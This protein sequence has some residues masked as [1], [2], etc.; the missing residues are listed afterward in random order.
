MKTDNL[1][2]VFNPENFIVQLAGLNI[3]LIDAATSPL[4]MQAIGKIREREFR[5]EG[6]GTGKEIDVDRFDFEAPCYRQLVAWDPQVKEIVAVYRF[7]QGSAVDPQKYQTQLASAE[8]FEFSPSFLS[9]YLP[10]V[11]E[12][13]RS[14]VNRSAQRGHKG[15]F[16]IWAGLGALVREHSNAEYFF[17]KFTVSQRL[18]ERLRRAMYAMLYYWRR[19][20]ENF[21]W[22]RAECRVDWDVTDWQPG[23]NFRE[24]LSRLIALAADLE[25]TIPPLVLTYVR[26]TDHIRVYGTAINAKFG[27]VEETA[28]LIPIKHIR[29][30]IR[31]NFIDSYISVNPGIFT[32]RSKLQ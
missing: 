4:A 3:H 15:L 12:L 2:K 28:I 27:N 25:A 20:E 14:V 29:P 18:P 30:K 26:L 6:G 31:R 16:A 21:I 1:Q 9:D 13:G 23:K 22:P 19:G 10:R 17:G 5:K 24:D 7:L 8:L 11:I 32:G